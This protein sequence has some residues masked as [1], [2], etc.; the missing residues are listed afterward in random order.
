MVSLASHQS[1][2]AWAMNS[3]PLS[4]HSDRAQSKQQKDLAQGHALAWIQRALQRSRMAMGMAHH[5]LTPAPDGLL[6]RRASVLGR[7]TWEGRHEQL[8][9]MVSSTLAAQRQQSVCSEHLLNNR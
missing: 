2:K 9:G 3:G 5:L 6:H 4:E 1:R 7:R 8:L